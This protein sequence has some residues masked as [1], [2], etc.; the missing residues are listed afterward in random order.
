MS[1][2]DTFEQDLLKLIFQNIAIADIGDVG[3][4]R[5]TVTAGSLWLSLHTADPG[6]AGTGV[7]SETAYTGYARKA[8]A[9]AAGAGG[10]TLTGSSISPTENQDFGECT[11]SPGGAITHFG[12]V[13]TASG[14][15]KVLYKGALTP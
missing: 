1:K 12:V 5:A 3:G 9:R 7:T 14:A 13:N 6:E 10:F 8:V 11:A 15:A 4:L 2:S